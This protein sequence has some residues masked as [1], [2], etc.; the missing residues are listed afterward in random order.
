[1]LIAVACQHWLGLQKC[2]ANVVPLLGGQPVPSTALLG[3]RIPAVGCSFGMVGA[4]LGLAAVIPG[5]HLQSWELQALGQAA[6][7]TA[8]HLGPW[9]TVFSSEWR[10]AIP[11]GRG[12]KKCLLCVIVLKGL[13]QF[14]EVSLSCNFLK[15]LWSWMRSLLS[16]SFFLLR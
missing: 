9:S 4:C 7:S 1:M 14:L 10:E 13:L 11:K 8:S 15:L 12:R 6:G 16:L 2:W 5:R 3:R